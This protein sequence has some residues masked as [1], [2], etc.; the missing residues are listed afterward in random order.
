MNWRALLFP[1]LL[2]PPMV[3]QT[4]PSIQTPTMN[5]EIFI[6]NRI[7]PKSDP[8]LVSAMRNLYRDAPSFREILGAFFAEQP[9]T[10]LLLQRTDS[11]ACV[12][13]DLHRLASGYL[14][15]VKVQDILE[16]RK[17]DHI[18]PWVAISF[19][20]VLEISRK[21]DLTETD[22]THY[23]ISE[24]LLKRIWKYQAR[25]RGDLRKANPLA[26]PLLCRDGEDL[27]LRTVGGSAISI[28]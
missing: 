20:A 2:F 22:E 18:E 28:S 23:L 6:A 21:Y 8:S 1:P 24:G 15:V 19:L 11:F 27:F 25:L 12:D 16:L 3:A 14:L 10:L 26:Y 4:P 13:I 9:N 7:H 17:K 5:L